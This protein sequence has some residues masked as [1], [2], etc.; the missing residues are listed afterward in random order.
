MRLLKI[1]DHGVA[2]GNTE[3]EGIKIEFVTK[4]P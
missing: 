2:G 4:T 1:F 3:K